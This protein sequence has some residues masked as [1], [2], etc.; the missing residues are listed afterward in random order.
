VVPETADD[1]WHVY[2]LIAVDDE[3]ECATTRKLKHESA[4]ESRRDASSRVVKLTLR[5]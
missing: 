5:V 4:A 3:V 1:V 2:N